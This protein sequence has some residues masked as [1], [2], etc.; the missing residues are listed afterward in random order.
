M[1]RSGRNSFVRND[2]I[3]FQSQFSFQDSF[4]AALQ[5][6]CQTTLQS[7]NDIQCWSTGCG[8]VR[9]VGSRNLFLE[10][11]HAHLL[12]GLDGDV[13]CKDFLGF[14]CHLGLRFDFLVILAG[15]PEFQILLAELGAQESSERGQ[16][17][18]WRRG[19]KEAE[20]GEMLLEG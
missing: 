9:G 13:F 11:F 3:S 6:W 7:L 5:V 12:T 10:R 4:T 8:Y 14:G 20:K 2:V 17:V 1:R 15:Q 18:W 16:P 19:E